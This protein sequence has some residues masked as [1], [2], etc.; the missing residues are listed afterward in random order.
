MDP[1]D[2]KTK[3]N[4]FYPH[5]RKKEKKKLVLFKENRYWFNMRRLVLVYNYF[6]FDYKSSSC[7]YNVF[8]LIF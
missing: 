4:W 2:K 5:S 3:I 6:E 7:C 1:N 8:L